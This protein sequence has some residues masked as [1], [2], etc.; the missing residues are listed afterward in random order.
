MA[1][2]L[3]L[4]QQARVAGQLLRARPGVE[5]LALAAEKLV[6]VARA[7]QELGFRIVPVYPA[8]RA[9]INWFRANGY[10]P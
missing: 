4:L 8:M 6:D 5:G 1:Q 10:A 7:Q 9:A 3:D 2:L